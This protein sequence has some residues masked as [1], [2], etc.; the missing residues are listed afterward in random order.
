MSA[1]KFP[2]I[3]DF[4]MLKPISRG[5]FGSTKAEGG[6]ATV[7]AAECKVYLARKKDHSDQLFAIKVVKKSEMVHKNMVDQVLAERN[8]LAVSC[9]PFVV[10]LF[11]CLQTPSCVHLV[12]DPALLGTLL[13]PHVTYGAIHKISFFLYR[14]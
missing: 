1:V 10:H 12:S 14:R 11:Y 5:A 4:V 3:D 2:S 9:S 6:S 7:R 13:E 8:A